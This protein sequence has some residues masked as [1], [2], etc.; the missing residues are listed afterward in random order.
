MHKYLFDMSI[1]FPPEVKDNPDYTCQPCPTNSTPVKSPGSANLSCRPC[2]GDEEWYSIQT[3]VDLQKNNL[4]TP[5][6]QT[7]IGNNGFTIES[8]NTNKSLKTYQKDYDD[9]S[10]FKAMNNTTGMCLSE[11]SSISSYEPYKGSGCSD[12]TSCMKGAPAF[13]ELSWP[14]KNKVYPNQIFELK[15]LNTPITFRVPENIQETTSCKVNPIHASKNKFHNPICDKSVI[16]AIADSDKCYL[17]IPVKPTPYRLREADLPPPGYRVTRHGGSST[18]EGPPCEIVNQLAQDY[19][20]IEGTTKPVLSSINDSV[21]GR[22]VDTGTYNNPHQKSGRYTA[23][24]WRNVIGMIYDECY[25]KGGRCYT[26]NYI[27]ETKTGAP[28]PLVDRTDKSNVIL[29]IPTASAH[30]CN[31]A[32]LVGGCKEHDAPCDALDV[33]NEGNIQTTTGVC[34]YSTWDTTGNQ[35]KIHHKQNKQGQNYHMRCFPKNKLKGKDILQSLFSGVK[36]NNI[37]EGKGQIRDDICRR[38]PKMTDIDIGSPISMGSP[39]SLSTSVGTSVEQISCTNPPQTTTPC[40]YPVKGTYNKSIKGDYVKQCCIGLTSD[41]IFS[42]FMKSWE[43][44]DWIAGTTYTPQF[45]KGEIGPFSTGP[46]SKP[47]KK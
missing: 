42:H 29:T 44:A 13:I 46:L 41:T 4:L 36:Y 3:L 28:I 14:K 2:K 15:N 8:H 6:Q 20:T 34:R 40:K 38:A 7:E 45:N 11:K 47:V 27:C 31:N 12:Y 24:D 26:H 18:G 25:D 1:W 10:K 32:V 39:C 5:E 19:N 22:K 30:G 43:D 21:K 37:L 9:L 16:P 35:W 17:R 33:D 23:T